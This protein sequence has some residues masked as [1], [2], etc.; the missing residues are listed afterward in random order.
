MARKFG[1]AESFTSLV[2]TS[3]Q[4]LGSVMT[5]QA[6]S[7][8][9]PYAFVVFEELHFTNVEFFFFRAFP[10]SWVGLYFRGSRL[11]FARHPPPKTAPQC[12]PK[13]SLSLTHF[14]P[15]TADLYSYRKAVSSSQSKL[16]EISNSFFFIRWV[17][18]IGIVR[19][20]KPNSSAQF[21]TSSASS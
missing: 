12:R 9:S 13:G 17:V 1:L 8:L 14:Y 16:S 11:R 10:T 15:T 5:V 21:R 18:C 6:R 3:C 4:M 2:C 20:I 19:Y 7:R